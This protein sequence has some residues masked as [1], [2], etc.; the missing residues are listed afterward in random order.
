MAKYLPMVFFNDLKFKV[1]IKLLQ[2]FFLEHLIS[3]IYS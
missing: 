3:F 1:C 2:A